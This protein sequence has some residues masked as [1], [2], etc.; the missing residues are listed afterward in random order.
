MR[1][2]DDAMDTKH[3]CMLPWI[4]FHAWPD[5]RV[6]PCC[7]ADSNLPVGTTDG[8]TI[9]DIMNSDRYKEIRLALLKDEPLK[10]CQRCYDLEN[11]GI[12]S[13]RQSNNRERFDIDM[14]DATNA[15]GSID[16]FK[17]KY[18]DI[19]FSNLCNMKCRSCGPACSSRWAEEFVKLHSKVEL[20]NNFNMKKIV[21]S[22]N[23]ND[24][25]LN[26]LE[27]HL[28]DVEEVY[29]A[30]GESLIT[31]EHY[32]I[33]DYWLANNH[34]D[35]RLTYTTNFLTLNFKK[36]S[37]IEYWKKFN[38]VQIWASLDASGKLIEIMRH[39]A[40][41]GA[42][43]NNINDMKKI[44]PHVK[45]GITPT[46]S[47]YNIHDFP[48]F[49]RWMLDN[50][51]VQIDGLRL[52]IL[53]YPWYMAVDIL[54]REISSKLEDQWWEHYF[55]LKKLYPDPEMEDHLGQIRT[56]CTALEN[57]TGNLEGVKKFFEMNDMLDECRDEW[58]ISTVPQ[59]RELY[60]WMIK[61]S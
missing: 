46:I 10:E 29:F 21:I 49:H 20:E 18:L 28:L 53:T 48:K 9:L 42:I 11:Y 36:K 40:D 35:V 5:K 51:I 3:F 25:L 15:D 57:S 16:S 12:W 33:L 60:S 41:W 43:L 1:T 34:T 2:F 31:D 13:L 55:Y 6:M 54:P 30:G 47:I 39:G 7:V 23:E 26:K 38:D 58:L 37:A 59:I 24:V 52:N 27:P 14:V 45:F 8:E 50:D 32:D 56:V 19:R 44:V 61:N 4:H 22:N 17:L